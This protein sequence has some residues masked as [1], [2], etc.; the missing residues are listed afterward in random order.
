MAQPDAAAS[1]MLWPAEP[2]KKEPPITAMGVISY[3]CLNSP[4]I[5]RVKNGETEWWI[6]EE[7]QY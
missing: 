6:H 1:D 2:G 5:N 3:R 7:M 4:T